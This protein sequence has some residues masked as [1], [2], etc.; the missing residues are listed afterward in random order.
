VI[1]SVSTQ[2]GA[3]AALLRPAGPGRL[4]LAVSIAEAVTLGADY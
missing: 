4:S 1:L 3:C 2:I